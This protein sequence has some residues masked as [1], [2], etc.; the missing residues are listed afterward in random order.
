[1]YCSADA[2]VVEPGVF[3]QPVAKGLRRQSQGMSIHIHKY[4]LRSTVDDGVAGCDKGQ[5]LRDDKIARKDSG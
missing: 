2:V 5:S 4:R 1:V 3:V